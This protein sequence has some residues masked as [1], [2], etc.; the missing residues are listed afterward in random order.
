MT[1]P[2]S[3]P[4]T[5]AM[6]RDPAWRGRLTACILGAIVLWPMLVASEFRPWQLLDPLALSAA[7]GFLASFVPPVTDVAFLH[8]VAEAAWITMAT[9]TAGLALAL[10]AAVPLTLAG[11]ARLS[12]SAIGRSM[13]R[14]PFAIR[15]LIRWLLIFLR[16]VPELVWA[17]LFVRVVGLGPTAGVL[18]IALTYCGMLGKVYAEVLESA[19]PAPGDAILKN[20]GSRLQAFLYGAL[21]QS[22]PELL[23]YTVF[24]WECAVRSSVIMGF[25]GGGG[26][27]QQ[28][29]MSMKMLAGG[30]VFTMLAVFVALVALADLVSRRLRNRMEHDQPAGRTRLGWLLALAALTVASFASL[31]LRLRELFAADG[32][33]KMSEFVLAFFPPE[34]SP[35]F[36][37]RLASGALETIAMSAIGTLIAAA[38]GLALALAASLPAGRDAAGVLRAAT[39]FLLNLLRSI[40]ELVWAA[41]WVIAAGLGPFPGTLALAAHTTGVIG[42]LYADTLE[43]LPP[44]PARALRANGAGGIAV[45]LYAT[46]PQAMP[47]MLSYTLYRWENNIRAA[48][49][50]GVVGAGGLGQMLHFHLSLFQME[51]AAAV[52]IAMLVIVAMVDALSYALRHRLGR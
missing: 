5:K 35:P 48:A 44:A 42:R 32:I 17:L 25:V 16:S 15:Q 45:F 7:G 27:G 43:N 36:L 18:A 50:L 29:E 8:L 49:V 30:E 37:A 34:A 14:L 51:Q 47:Q 4:V 22:A 19:D 9:A 26:L 2:L 28:M 13:G 23:S 11:T 6:L 38:L 46:L 40:P 1:V 24:R 31:D 33:A 3:R 12:Q 52:V 10:L 39:R 20:G 21:P 41:L